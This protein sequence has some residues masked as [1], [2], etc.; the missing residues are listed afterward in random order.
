MQPSKEETFDLKKYEKVKKLFFNDKIRYYEIVNQQTRQKYIGKIWKKNLNDFRKKKI[1]DLYR[2]VYILSKIHHPSFLQFIGFSLSDFKSESKPVIVFEHISKGP[3][4][5]ILNL[6]DDKIYFETT[7]DDENAFKLNE[8]QKLILIYGI[9]SGM[10]YLHSHDIIHRNLNPSC[11]FFD[12]SFLPKIS[13]FDI[14][15]DLSK[16]LPLAEPRK[17]SKLKGEGFYLAPE[18]WN[19]LDYG[20]PSDVYSFALLMYEIVTN[21]T[22]S[23]EDEEMKTKIDF[24]DNIPLCYKELIERCCSENPKDRPTFSEIESELKNNKEF[25]T[26]EVDENEFKKYIKFIENSKISFD[27]EKVIKEMDLILESNKLKRSEIDDTLRGPINSSSDLDIRQYKTKSDKYN[28]SVVDRKSGIRFHADFCN[29]EISSFLRYEIINFARSVNILA[30]VNHPSIVKFVGYSPIDFTFQPKPVFITEDFEQFD[31]LKDYTQKLIYIYGVASGMAYLHSH[32]ILHR[33]LKPANIMTNKYGF[34]KIYGFDIAKE[35]KSDEVEPNKR[36]KG[37]PVYIAPEVYLNKGY[38][39]KSDVY[40]FSLIMYEIFTEEQPFDEYNEFNSPFEIKQRIVNEQERPKF[41][42]PINESYKT[43]IERCWSQE[44]SSRPSFSEIITELKTNPDFITDSVDKETFFEY[45]AYI[46][47]FNAT[48]DPSRKVKQLDD[49]LQNKLY[50]FP[51]IKPSFHFKNM[52]STET[53]NLLVDDEYYLN[54]NDFNGAYFIKNGSFYEVSKTVSAK[55]GETLVEKKSFVR[56]KFYKRHEII[57]FS[58]ELNILLQLN[59]PSIL[60]FFGYTL[61]LHE[62]PIVFTEFSANGPLGRILKMERIKRE[63]LKNQINNHPSDNNKKEEEIKTEKE[64]DNEKEGNEKEGNTNDENNEKVAEEEE[65]NDNDNND[66]QMNK[67]GDRNYNENVSLDDTKKLIIIY[68]IAA[69]MSYLHSHNILHRDLKPYN[70]YLDDSLYPKI[71]G[72]NIAKEMKSGKV[73]PNK[74]IKGTPVYIAP[75]VYLNKGY[76]KKSDVYSFSLIMYEI[77][78]EEQ[79]F[80]EYNEFNSPFEIKQRIVNEQERPKFIKPINESYKTLIERCWSQE[81][82]SRPSF[83]EIIT[84]L[85]TNPD[86]ITDSIN[87]EEFQAYV[88][89]IDESPFSFESS[90]RIVGLE[91]FVRNRKEK[92]VEL[93]SKISFRPVFETEANDVKT[94]FEYARIDEYEKQYLIRNFDDF[95]YSKLYLIKHK[96]TKKKFFAKK[97]LKDRRESDSFRYFNLSHEI[98]HL[99]EVK[100]PLFLKFLK[101]SPIDFKRRQHPILIFESASNGTLERMIAIN[102][103]KKDEPLLNTKKLILLYGI[104]TAMS[105]LHSINIIHCRLMP[106]NIYLDD[107]LFPKIAGFDDSKNLSENPIIPLSD[108]LIGDSLLEDYSIYHAPEIMKSAIYSSAS[109]VY[110]FAVIAYEL[111]TDEIPFQDDQCYDGYRPSFKETTP[112]CYQNLI[113]KCWNQDPKERPTF[114]EIVHHIKTNLEFFTNI[115]KEEFLRFVRFT[116]E[117]R[118]KTVKNEILELNNYIQNQNERFR[119]IK[120][121]YSKLTDWLRI[122]LNVNIG[123]SD[124]NH[125]LKQKKIGNGSFGNVYK[126]IEIEKDIT[127]AAKISIYEIDQ[128]S[129]DTILNLSR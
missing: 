31:I 108:I 120:L 68:G 41:I 22:P 3:L 97:I 96:E 119:K 105:Y 102:R 103:R 122:N 113:S 74:R 47:E 125:F 16:S 115:D 85:K 25:I 6:Q 77:F 76:S 72:F 39:K 106:S 29:K 35:I 87:K 10:S 51:D 129:E 26:S 98:N 32:N 36:I 30:Q 55:T 5:L 66:E 14:V 70:V 15:K 59:H 53:N 2:E 110:S 12:D 83:S 18:I 28:V 123:S 63:E 90:R 13:G 52:Y 88:K 43:L 107:F 117:I 93:K 91:S 89:Y 114:E 80:D 34:P 62:E 4:S 78:T 61:H 9:A 95:N 23:F 38:S 8:T 57:N 92:F 126:V 100:H 17:D 104:A 112:T 56:S 58:K 45:V 71:S 94:D 121:D 101:Y 1:L 73:E 75:E 44:P 49:I 64:N 20:K 42:K 84:E 50:S 111:I 67:M 33:N 48:F 99:L 109:D 86:F 21:E 19:K 54:I 7:E 118:E 127:Y 11:I 79:P 81:P 27:T 60:K 116:E 37:T 69:G 46:D 128:C 65:Y 24:D 124:L 82:S 40:S